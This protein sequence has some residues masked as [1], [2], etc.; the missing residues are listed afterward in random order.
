MQ[1]NP[2]LY[3]FSQDL[4][5]SAVLFSFI[6]FNSEVLLAN[7]LLC[8][9]SAHS[10]HHMHTAAKIVKVLPAVNLYAGLIFLLYVLVHMLVLWG[11][12]L[13]SCNPSICVLCFS[14]F[15]CNA[16]HSLSL[17]LN[18]QTHFLCKQAVILDLEDPVLS[19]W[20]YG[21]NLTWFVLRR[22]EIVGTKWL[23]QRR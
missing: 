12:I 21:P 14:C 19:I 10:V 5:P 18:W 16:T 7:I 2:F 4:T 1:C 17:H 22:K 3:C 23:K 8:Y 13:C 11:Q 20:S 15:L 9:V 6:L